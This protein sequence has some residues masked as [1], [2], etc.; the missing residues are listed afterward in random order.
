MAK[1]ALISGAS[2]G[3]GL[4]ISKKLLEMDYR[5][6]GIARDFSQTALHHENFIQLTCDLTEIDTMEHY[7]KQHTPLQ[8]IDLLVNNAGFGTFEPHE[9]LPTKTII[10]MTHLNLLAPMILTKLCLR[11]L[12]KHKGFIF[13]INSISGIKPAPYGAVYGACKSGLNHFGT[14]LFEEARKSGL[15]VININPDITKTN[16][17]DQLHFK[18]DEDPLSYIDPM[19]IAVIIEESLNR[20]EGTVITDITIQPQRFRIQK[21]KTVI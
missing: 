16:F 3:I 17:F 18:N 11:S 7:L 15:K 10:K 8:E 21:K 19:D 4:E 1:T 6:Y 14:S 9:E 20:R 12:K 13:N 5:V 2:S